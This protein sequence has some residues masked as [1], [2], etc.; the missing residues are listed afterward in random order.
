MHALIR[1]AAAALL[2]IATASVPPLAAQIQAPPQQERSE[3][4][5][6]PRPYG[7]RIAVDPAKVRVSDGDTVELDWGA[8]GRESVRI[9]G[10]DTPEIAHPDYNM[11][12]AQSFGYEARAFAM[13]AFAAATKVEVLRSD[14]LDTYGRTLGYLYVNDLN[15]SVLVIRA[16]LGEETVSRYG[17]N[18]LPEQ[19]A[20][21]VA[22][23][24]A[25]GPMPFESPGQFRRRMR[26][27]S[28]WMR[29]QGGAPRE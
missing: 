27:V 3:R 8:Q 12:Y 28:G 29:D 19:A 6:Q 25:A 22:A 23:A 20:E 14:M 7:K 18:G 24:K 1:A 10:I 4:A 17:D 5:P 13:G 9:L 15:Y 11:P 2:A 21:I 26:D 16:R